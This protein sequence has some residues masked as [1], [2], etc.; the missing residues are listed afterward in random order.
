MT[1]YLKNRYMLAVVFVITTIALVYFSYSHPE[2]ADFDSL[3]IT[4]T[5]EVI[6]IADENNTFAWLGI[7]YAQPPLGKLRWRAAQPPAQWKSTFI[8]NS[9][10]SICP[11]LGDRLS[12]VSR[13]KWNRL[14]G[15]E[16]CLHL[17]IWAPKTIQVN[18][19]AKPK[20]LPVMVW[21]HG[22]GNVK[23]TA[24]IYRGHKLA[25][26]NNVIVVTLNYR[27]GFLGWSGHNIVRE[28]AINTSDASGNYGLL[29]VIAALNWIQ[30][31]IGEFGGDPENITL[32]GE[33]A[34]ARNIY[35]LVAS[36]LAEGL[37]DKVII[38][39]G[40]VKTHALSESQGLQ[41][42]DCLFGKD[43]PDYNQLINETQSQSKKRKIH[44]IAERL[45]NTSVERLFE[46]WNPPALGMYA[47]R[48]GQTL[49]QDPLLELFKKPLS[50][51]SVP[52]LIGS[53]RDENKVYMYK[54][55]N[56][57]S[58]RFGFLPH[59]KDIDDYNRIT[60]YY[61]D[62]WKALAVDEPSLILSQSNQ[63]P[64]Y[65][66]RFDWDEQGANWL[67][68]SSNLIGASHG[69]EVNFVF[70]DFDTGIQI[71]FTNTSKN[72]A[73]REKL[74]RAIRAYWSNFARFGDPNNV[75]ESNRLH[76]NAW[77]PDSR[78]TM[79]F[80]NLPAGNRIEVVTE[81][82]EQLKQ[83]LINDRKLSQ[84]QRCE[85][86][87]DIFMT[88]LQT[89]AYGQEKEYSSFSDGVCAWPPLLN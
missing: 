18:G 63:S 16:D 52:I 31:N 66:Y 67:I 22:G 7:P 73:G 82:A 2:P 23:G 33:S 42:D 21:V 15:S 43:L 50:Y 68:D 51:N 79:I 81:T 89:S 24:N 9:F 8:A 59:I 39:S 58:M 27:L 74:S 47:L 19:D 4:N 1:N 87:Q 10:R 49:S 30:K 12:G 60:G 3:R 80:D 34:G 35:T 5:G 77:H 46:C 37:F 41:N 54:N 56:L 11:Q 69:M 32:F 26:D 61:S 76:W 13:L 86:Y 38:Q 14:V 40:S 83:K 48:D 71:P 25:G 84:E 88:S 62:A 28:S 45:R 53:N 20:S 36:E 17:N 44:E 57:V 78:Q 55:P 72:A 70:G 65:I 29:D 6:G 75:N 85:I 64:I